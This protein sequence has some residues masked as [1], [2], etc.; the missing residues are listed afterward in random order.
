MP[1]RD[2]DR[3]V[4]L[5]S[6]SMYTMPVAAMRRPPADMVFKFST[7][8]TGRSVNVLSIRQPTAHVM[9]TDLFSLKKRAP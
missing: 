9:T 8:T 3:D 7:F 6:N 5:S 4:I 2:R 1:L